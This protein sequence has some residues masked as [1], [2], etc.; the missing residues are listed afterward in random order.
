MPKIKPRQEGKDVFTKAQHAK[1]EY[2]NPR[3]KYQLHQLASWRINHGG[4]P[5]TFSKAPDG[6]PIGEWYNTI[7]HTPHTLNRTQR[8]LVLSIPGARLGPSNPSGRARM[9]TVPQ[10]ELWDKVVEFFNLDKDGEAHGR[11]DG[12]KR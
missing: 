12:A 6:Y 10:N 1:L 11:K 4:M 9:R 3:F 8:A 2:L 7:R 5:T